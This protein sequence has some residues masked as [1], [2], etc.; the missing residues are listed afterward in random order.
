MPIQGIEWLLLSAVIIVVVYLVYRKNR[1]LD[2]MASITLRFVTTRGRSSIADIVA[3][4]GIPF[5]DVY[6][7]VERLYKHGLVDI[8]K[9]GGVVTYV[10]PR[11]GASTFQGVE[12]A[13][14]GLFGG[15]SITCPRC[16]H[17]NKPGSR[18]CTECGSRLE[19]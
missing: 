17:G 14:E 7:V 10:I 11:G 12:S 8:V 2:E 15:Q 16:G 19:G 4:A 1:K 5:R 18:Y 9:E 13:T 3:N 6:K